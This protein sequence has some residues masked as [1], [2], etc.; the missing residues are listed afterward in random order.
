MSKNAGDWQHDAQV[1]IQ[2]RLALWKTQ[3]RKCFYCSAPLGWGD[4]TIDHKIPLSRG[5]TDAWTNIVVACL[6]C[7]QAKADRIIIRA[8]EL[9]A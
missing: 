3:K 6:N 8:S 1:M 5:G 2:R 4:A 7:N 9:F